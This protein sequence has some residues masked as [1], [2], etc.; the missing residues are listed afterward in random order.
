MNR[1]QKK[2]KTT[3]AAIVL[4]LASVLGLL[5]TDLY[6]HYQIELDALHLR[7]EQQT[8]GLQDDVD[9][10]IGIIKGL[11]TT[12]NIHLANADALKSNYGDKLGLI[13]ETGGYGLKGLPAPA[14]RDE[15]LNLTGLGWYEEPGVMEEL[16]AALSLEP[17]FKWVKGMYP[18][19]PWVYYLSASRFMAVYPYIPFE[20]FFMED[21]FYRMDLYRLGTPELN[22]QRSHYVTPVYEDEA[23]KGLM[24]TIGAPVYRD[25]KFTGIAGFDLTLA[26]LS[27][28][29]RSSHHPGDAQFLLNEKG[30]IIA[31][32][33]GD[34]RQTEIFKPNLLEKVRPGLLARI[35]EGKRKASSFPFDGRSIHATRIKNTHW[36]LVSERSRLVLLKDAATAG[37][38]LPLFLLV[39]GIGILMFIRERRLQEHARTEIRLVQERDKLQQMVDEQT[40]DLTESKDTAEAAAEAKS[41]FLANMSHEIR[42]PLNAVL[43]FAKLGQRDSSE[44]VSRRTF[45]QILTSGELLLQVINDILDFSKIEAGKLTLETAPFPLSKT[46]EETLEMVAARAQK[47]ALSVSMQIDNT[48][49]DWVMG[50]RFRLQQVLINVLSNAIKFTERGGISLAGSWQEGRLYLQVSDS[51]I[52]LTVEQLTRAFAPF[53]QA[54]SSTTREHGGTGLGLPI[55]RDLVQLMGGTITVTSQP[56]RGSKFT[57]CVP[58]SITQEPAAPLSNSSPSEARRLEGL[59]ILAAEDDAVNRSLLEYLLTREGARVVFAE[60]GQEAL[61]KIR[62]RG[63]TEFD[64][65][66]MDVQMPV[67]DGYEATRR[68]GKIAPALPVIGVTAHALAEEYRK[69]REAGMIAHVTK[70]CEPDDLI[71]QIL[72]HHDQPTR[73]EQVHQRPSK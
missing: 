31:Q 24:V 4:I 72:M 32:A 50:D 12:A 8:K 21:G 56:G 71:R 41:R 18:E 42:T 5:V 9:T 70:P 45:E 64:V 40:Q 38:P 49:P 10:A 28:S 19:T 29:I 60:N 44:S 15:R 63:A 22:P 53:E 20:E 16:E 7:H 33:G 58:L 68:I 1:S 27:R 30:D 51:G 59:N 37:L 17:I 66:L 55:A 57:V 25:D 43:G 6:K 2:S 3:T 35:E 23:G 13:Q 67:M 62:I 26:S 69:G 61:D 47:K 54:D 14:S 46:I 39:L 34:N 65:V 11:Q 48:V 36:I 52:G 73:P